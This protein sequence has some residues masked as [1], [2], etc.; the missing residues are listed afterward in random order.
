MLPIALTKD[1]TGKINA[2]I[3]ACATSTPSTGARLEG[4]V[5]VAIA[6][7]TLTVTAASVAFPGA[8][9]LDAAKQCIEQRAVGLSTSAGDQEDLA[10][11]KIGVSFRLP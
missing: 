7:H 4:D 8:S 6:N 3:E 2:V 10:D 9:G 11:Y 1:I 5:T